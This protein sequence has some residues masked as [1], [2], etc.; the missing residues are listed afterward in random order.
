MGERDDGMGLELSMLMQI[1][2][3]LTSLRFSLGYIQGSNVRTLTAIFYG[4]VSRENV[5]E[6][7]NIFVLFEYL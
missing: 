3:A 7:M 2:L 6:L 5:N 1:R 4:T